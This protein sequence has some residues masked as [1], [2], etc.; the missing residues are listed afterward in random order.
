MERRHLAEPALEVGFT[1]M[2]LDLAPI[3]APR[4]IQRVVARLA[5][6]IARRYVRHYQ[7]TAAADL[8]AV[9]YFEALRC[10]IELSNV[11]A[12]R[13]AKSEAGPLDRPRPT[14]DRIADSMVDYFQSRTGVTVRLPALDSEP[15]NAGGR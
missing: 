1:T 7:R 3:E 11:A 6:G 4:P 15:R 10:L 14:W 8:S 5:H 9:P 12:Y 2:S 13:R